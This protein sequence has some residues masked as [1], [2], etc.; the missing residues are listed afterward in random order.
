MTSNPPFTFGSYCDNIKRLEQSIKTNID[1]VKG[2]P[3]LS[4][5]SYI[6]PASGAGFTSV[7]NTGSKSFCNHMTEM[8]NQFNLESQCMSINDR[9]GK[10]TI[11][12][13]RFSDSSPVY[14]E[15]KGFKKSSDN[16]SFTC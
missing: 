3:D 10:V 6:N 2:N 13:V 14:F 12:G 16:F 15:L 1:K 5:I 8:G 9:D 7:V 4:I 11:S